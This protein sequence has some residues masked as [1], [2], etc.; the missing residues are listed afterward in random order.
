[1]SKPMDEK[2]L[3]QALLVNLIMML[4]SSAMQQMGKLV[5][6][7]SGKAETNLEAAQLTIDMLEMLRAKTRGNLDPREESLLTS[8]L[9]TL[10]L[11]YVETAREQPAEGATPP[12]AAE[13]PVD[14]PAQDAKPVDAKDP[15]FRKSYG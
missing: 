14:Q 2:E 5:D 4:S 8:T 9:S 10:Q 12:P 15:K 11:T 7:A 1:M 6:P 13:L 3:H